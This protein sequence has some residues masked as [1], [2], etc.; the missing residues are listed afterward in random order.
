MHSCVPK[1]RIVPILVGISELRGT[2]RK[3]PRSS[4]I[5]LLIDNNNDHQYMQDHYSIYQYQALW[6]GSFLAQSASPLSG[7]R[8]QDL[9]L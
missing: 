3:L 6:S 2:K 5:H 4:R 1:I 7:I 9:R 8:T